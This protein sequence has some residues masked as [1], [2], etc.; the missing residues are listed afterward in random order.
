MKI[1]YTQ[2]IHTSNLIE[3]EKEKESLNNERNDYKAKLLKLDE[4]NKGWEKERM[5]QI[6]NEKDLK[7]KLTEL[8]KEV[9]ENKKDSEVQNF[10]PP[11]HANA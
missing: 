2:L 9:N 4:E 5:I 11:A 6:E 1:P 3:L 10:P 8:E 7:K